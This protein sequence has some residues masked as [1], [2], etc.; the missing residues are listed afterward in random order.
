MNELR[1]NDINGSIN[2]DRRGG[3]WRSAVMLY[4]PGLNISLNNTVGHLISWQHHPSDT[5][6]HPPLWH[7]FKHPDRPA[8]AS[9]SNWLSQQGPGTLCGLSF[10]STCPTSINTAIYWPL[11]ANEVKPSSLSGKTVATQVIIRST[12]RLY[13]HASSKQKKNLS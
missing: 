11:R 1:T 6:R 8:I 7:P 5:P 10:D 12:Q 4:D 9:K 2:T 3:Q 13:I